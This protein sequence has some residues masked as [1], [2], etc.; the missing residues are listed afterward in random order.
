EALP[1][2]IVM[3][4]GVVAAAVLLL[5]TLT[6]VPPAGAAALSVTVA[7]EEAPP[8]TLVGLKAIVEAAGVPPPLPGPL[9]ASRVV[10]LRGATARSFE[11]PLNR[12][13][14]AP[15]GRRK[16]SRGQR[17]RMNSPHLM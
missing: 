17:K 1:A 9:D 4:A 12:I 16:V 13:S 14:R 2:G 5:V 6:T 7:V 8:T 11:H 10:R 3:L 15:R